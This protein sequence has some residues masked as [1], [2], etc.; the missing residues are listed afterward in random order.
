MIDV[1]CEVKPFGPDQLIVNGPVP[2]AMLSVKV[3][4]VPEQTSARAGVMLALGVGLTVNTPE[5]VTLQWDEVVTVTLYVPAI[6]T[7]IV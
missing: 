1:A 6:E 2:L 3:W 4:L 5:A 7:L